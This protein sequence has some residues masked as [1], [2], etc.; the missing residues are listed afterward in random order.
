MEKYCFSC[1]HAIQVFV[2]LHS[3]ACMHACEMQI[4]T[5]TCLYYGPSYGHGSYLDSCCAFYHDFCSFDLFSS[6][7]IVTGFSSIAILTCYDP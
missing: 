6:N 7:E 2:M 1:S 3:S 5:P 4:I